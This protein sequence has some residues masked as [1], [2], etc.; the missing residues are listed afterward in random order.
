MIAFIHLLIYLFNYPFFNIA[1]IYLDNDMYVVNSL[2]KYRK[3]EMTVSWPNELR[4]LGV[5]ILIAHKN[6]RFLKTHYDSYRYVIFKKKCIHILIP[7]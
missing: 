4:S 7:F 2:H 6:A 1:G 3:Y 5:Q